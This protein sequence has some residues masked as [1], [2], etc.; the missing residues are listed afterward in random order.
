MCV[1]VYMGYVYSSAWLYWSMFAFCLILNMLLVC[2]ACCISSA[3]ASVLVCQN[4]NNF[5]N[6]ISTNF[7]LLHFFLL[8]FASR[9]FFM[10]I[11]CYI[12]MYILRMWVCTIHLY[13]ACAYRYSFFVY[14]LSTFLLACHILHS[15]LLQCMFTCSEIFLHWLSH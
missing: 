15:L 10:Y 5:A 9:Y 8:L 13:V 14:M 4:V 6:F 3:L 1:C 12:C 2:L 11:G 7:L